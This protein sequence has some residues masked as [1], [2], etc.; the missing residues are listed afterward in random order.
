VSAATVEAAA[1]AHKVARAVSLTRPTIFDSGHYKL[2]PLMVYQLE[3]PR[4]CYTF[5]VLRVFDVRGRTQPPSTTKVVC[6][7]NSLLMFP[8]R[9]CA[10]LCACSKVDEACEI[11]RNT[12]WKYVY[13]PEC[14]FA[15]VF[16][17]VAVVG[18]DA[19]SGLTTVHVTG[20][21]YRLRTQ[22]RF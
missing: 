6:I 4:A 17:T 14:D 5:P 21:F 22:D 2:R 8:V 3:N 10:D 12:F 15:L 19:S 11:V 1:H 13:S 20:A 7:L 9:L 18:A 16:T